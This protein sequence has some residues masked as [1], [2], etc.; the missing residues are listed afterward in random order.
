MQSFS[1]GRQAL[2]SQLTLPLDL[3]AS[4]QMEMMGEKKDMIHS[5]M[6]LQKDFQDCHFQY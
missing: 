2:V 4:V 1:T 3:K 6:S 5:M